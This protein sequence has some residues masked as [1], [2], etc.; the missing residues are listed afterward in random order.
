MQLCR[1]PYTASKNGKIIKTGYLLS[2]KDFNMS[3]R[4]KDLIDAGVTSLK[5]EGRAR[6]EGY[7]SAVVSTYRQIL[8][9]NLATTEK[10]QQTLQKAFNRGDFTQG[11]FNG[12]QNIIDNNIQGHKGLEIGKIIDVKNGKRF[13]T[14][15]LLSKHQ[16]NKKP[17]MHF[18]V[19]SFTWYCPLLYRIF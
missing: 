18:T 13:N 4:L 8:D 2:A 7:V 3:K 10:H 12:N 5:I 1:L 19:R 17:I 11:Y 16:P 14:I 15:T 6:R 9:N